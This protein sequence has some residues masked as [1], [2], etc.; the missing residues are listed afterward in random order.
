MEPLIDITTASEAQLQHE[1][2]RL[3]AENERLQSTVE[4]LRND[5]SAATATLRA[6]RQ[7]RERLEAALQ[8]SNAR[9]SG[10]RAILLPEAYQAAVNR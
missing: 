9:R 5:V 2:A 4:R 8:Q 7:H 6:E 10:V 1:C 3:G